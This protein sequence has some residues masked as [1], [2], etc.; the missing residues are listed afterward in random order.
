MLGVH[1]STVSDTAQRIQA[2]GLIRYSRGIIKITNRN[3]L[4]QSHASATAF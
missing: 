3:E 1:R 2:Q 4:K